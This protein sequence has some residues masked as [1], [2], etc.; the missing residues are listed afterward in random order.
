MHA[1]E[2]SLVQ[3]VLGQ[4]H[5]SIACGVQA[6]RKATQKQVG[7]IMIMR[8]SKLKNLLVNMALLETAAT[9]YQNKCGLAN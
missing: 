1:R 8:K 2:A 9:G 3:R 6:Q 7:L 4:P 5:T